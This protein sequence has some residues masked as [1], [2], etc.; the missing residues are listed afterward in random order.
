MAS[1]YC[2]RSKYRRASVYI[3]PS[4]HSRDEWRL[5]DFWM[6][7]CVIGSCQA[8]HS[9]QILHVDPPPSSSSTSLPTH[10]R[11]KYIAL[12]YKCAPR[13]VHISIDDQVA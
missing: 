1:S 3:C 4:H 7:A 5:R 9:R 13:A 8:I 12:F 6:E 10:H 11:K 2:M